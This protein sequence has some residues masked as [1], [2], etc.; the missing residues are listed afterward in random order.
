MKTYFAYIRVSTVKQGKEG[1]SLKEQ[2]SAIE[3]FAKREGLLI[4][5]WYEEQQTAAKKGRAEFLKMMS[6]L[7]KRAAAGVILHKID[8]GARNLWDWARIQGLLDAGLEVHFAHDNLDMK[9]RGGRLA[10]DI[11]AVVAADFVRNLREEI[12]KG[13]RGR[14]KEGLYPRGAPLGYG[15]NG[16]G[17][18]KTIDPAKGPLVRLAFELYASRR[19]SFHTLR[20]ELHRQGLT[21][22]SGG[23][24]NLCSITALLRN[25]FYAGVIRL[26]STGEHFPGIHEPLISANLFREVQNVL[27]GKL[28][29]RVTKHDFLY[30]RLFRCGSCGTTLIGE[31]QKGIVYYRCHTPKCPTTG[32]REDAISAQLDYTTS[33]IRFSEGDKQEMLPLIDEEEKAFAKLKSERIRTAGLKVSALEEREHR[34]T[35]AYLDRLIDEGT[36]RT[37]QAA[38]LLELTETREMHRRALNDDNGIGLSIRRFFEFIG[39]LGIDEAKERATAFREALCILTSNRSVTGKKPCITLQSPFLE[40]DSELAVLFSAAARYTPRTCTAKNTAGKKGA[41]QKLGKVGTTKSHQR[42][43]ILTK[44]LKGWKPPLSFMISEPARPQRRAP[45]NRP[46]NLRR[47]RADDDLREAA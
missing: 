40:L 41:V 31:K 36:Y 20:A 30:R 19:Y 35:D 9:S 14:L 12:R 25:P 13:Q 16:K 33:G 4:S 15:N 5:E 47:E 24:L 34:L 28:N 37:R 46:Q 8:R 42:F 22:R 32:I 26:N 6:R 2:R 18:V 44:H 45:P 11:Q 10:A 17:K 23:V 39:A 38:L 29:T 27:D 3:A 7:E 43:Q 21:R 1:S